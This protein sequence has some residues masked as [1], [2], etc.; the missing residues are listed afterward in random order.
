MSPITFDAKPC[1]T[2]CIAVDHT[3]ESTPAEQTNFI[4]AAYV[5]FRSKGESVIDWEMKCERL[6]M[7]VIKILPGEYNKGEPIY[8]RNQYVTR[9]FSHNSDPGNRKITSENIRI[10]GDFLITELDPGVGSG[11]FG[12]ET[13]N[14][15]SSTKHRITT[16][17]STRVSPTKLA[18]SGEN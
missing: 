18:S 2:L 16:L 9:A 6:Q 12:L 17:F 14:W 3:L 13:K 8:T 5:S 1:M 11:T 10:S 7:D 4:D 15:T